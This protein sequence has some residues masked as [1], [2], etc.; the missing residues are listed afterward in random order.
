[1]CP[2]ARLKRKTKR[3]FDLVEEDLNLG[4][5]EPSRRKKW[6]AMLAK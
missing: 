4:E 2:C 1:M 5:K 3:K 6:S